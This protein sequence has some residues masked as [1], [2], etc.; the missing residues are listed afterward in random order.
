[1]NLIF[2]EPRPERRIT[3]FESDTR[4]TMSKTRASA[5]GQLERAK[6]AREVHEGILQ[7]NKLEFKRDT[8]WRKLDAEVRKIIKKLQA[9]SKIEERERDMIARREAATAEAE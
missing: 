8:V 5:Q 9:I 7:K 1:M 2:R 6:K 3:L 4:I